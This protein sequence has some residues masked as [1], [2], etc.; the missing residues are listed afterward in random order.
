MNTRQAMA[1]SIQEWATWF[2]EKGLTEK[3]KMEDGKET[4]IAFRVKHHWNVNKWTVK[5]MVHALRVHSGEA[6]DLAKYKGLRVN[7]IYGKLEL[8][9]KIFIR[10]NLQSLKVK[11]IALYVQTSH[12][13]ARLAQNGSFTE[14]EEHS[15]EPKSERPYGPLNYEEKCEIRDNFQL[16]N[17]MDLARRYNTHYNNILRAQKGHFA[18]PAAVKQAAATRPFGPLTLDE[19]RFIRDNRSTESAANLAMEYNTH[20][21]NIKLAQ[22][23]RFKDLKP[24]GLTAYEKYLLLHALLARIIDSLPGAAAVLTEEMIAVYKET[25]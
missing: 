13:N 4:I 12:A 10:D 3:S 15:T 1:L 14:Q 6:P 22:E 25:S 7:A 8:D 11:D 5:E 24:V 19:K 9:Q 2:I 17:A 21:G 16:K 20:Q 23:G 18:I